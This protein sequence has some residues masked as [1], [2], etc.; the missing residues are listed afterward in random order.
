M[1]T[2]PFDT[3]GPHI[4]VAALVGREPFD[5]EVHRPLKMVAFADVEGP[6]G[7]VWPVVE[8]GVGAGPRRGAVPWYRALVR[9]G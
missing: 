5:P 3:V 7:V 6:I 8:T 1:H 9:S 4:E 2:Y